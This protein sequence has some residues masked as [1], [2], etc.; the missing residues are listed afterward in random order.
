MSRVLPTFD[1]VRAA[2]QRLL[3][4]AHRTPVLRSATLE[5]R[6]GAQ[7]FF[8]CENFQRMGAFKFRGAYHAL[9]HLTTEQKQR[10]VITHSSG[11]HAQA[12]ALAA[13]QGK[14][15]PGATF[16]QLLDKYA[17]EVSSKKKGELWETNK[18]TYLQRQHPALCATK[19]E[20][21]CTRDFALWR[22]ARLKA[23]TDSSVSREWTLLSR[24]LTIA[25][26]E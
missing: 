12:L 13:K 15:P 26:T 4:H 3:G 18:I 20:V 5:Q 7:L 8:K 1:D 9:A 14:A 23:V 2:A 24:A 10:G 19:V 16:A 25:Q 6:L 21:L 17:K 11:N 22:D